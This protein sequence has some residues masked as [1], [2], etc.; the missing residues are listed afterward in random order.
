M[1]VRV[2]RRSWSM[3]NKVCHACVRLSAQRGVCLSVSRPECVLQ[4]PPLPSN[5][6]S[7]RY[8]VLKRKNVRWRR[9]RARAWTKKNKWKSTDG[10]NRENNARRGKSALCT[11]D[12]FEIKPSSL[13]CHKTFM[14]CLFIR[15]SP[16]P[17]NATVYF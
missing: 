16:L 9:R 12:H 15:S 8:C 11:V 1:R 13:L 14:C 2:M 7:S 17:V 6:L 5:S 10:R 4:S 3:C